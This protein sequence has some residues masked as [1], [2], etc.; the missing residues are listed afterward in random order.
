MSPSLYEDSRFN[1]WVELLEGL[2]D[3]GGV[4]TP[5]LDLFPLSFRYFAIL[6]KTFMFLK[7]FRSNPKEVP[8]A[9]VAAN[10]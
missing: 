5:I 9:K 10:I 8:K 7:E 6:S 1:L 4:K 3:I 2:S